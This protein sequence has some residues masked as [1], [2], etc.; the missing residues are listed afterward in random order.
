MFDF[1]GGGG[2]GKGKEG[3]A[4]HLPPSSGTLPTRR[5]YSFLAWHPDT[6]TFLNVYFLEALQQVWLFTPL[7]A[8]VW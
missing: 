3:E 1:M 4:G 8:F 2:G 7:H 5:L 6:R